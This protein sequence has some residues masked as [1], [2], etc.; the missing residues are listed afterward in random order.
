MTPIDL[1]R[2]STSFRLTL[3]AALLL[4]GSIL[5]FTLP[6]LAQTTDDTGPTFDNPVIDMNFPDP[7]MLK[8]ED[9]YYAYS[10]NS[11]SR[12]VPVA[13]STDL[14]NWKIGRDVMPAL[15]KWVN[16]SGPDVWAPEVLQVD[17]QFLLYY[18]ARDKASGRQCIGV[19]VSE[20]PGGPFRDSSDQALICQVREGGSIDASPFRDA[21]GSLYLYWKNDGNC[22]MMATWLYGQPL[23]DDGL[24]LV[25]EPVQL[26]R[27]DTLWEGTVVEAPSMWQHDDRYYLFYSGNM[28]STEK[29][30]VGYAVCET[31]LGPCEDAEENPILSSDMDE[32]P[33]V[34]GPGHQTLV[35]DEAGETW[36]YY[37]V[38][39]VTR[40]GSITSNR[41][42]WLDR[43]IWEDGVP[44]VVGPTREDQPVPVTAGVGPE[45]ETEAT[46]ETEASD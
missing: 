21:D 43:V 10:T 16:F 30:A 25:D 29:Y 5:I 26:V 39:E 1:H 15:A 17:D 46:A 22:C 23:S 44:S 40:S 3:L 8:V 9:T 13:T 6:V 45:T 4:I 38:W 11:S 36:I 2:F 27:N 24:T 32:Q 35:M 28:Y 41:E 33:L 19:A 12:N 42:V 7:F 34:V 14:V 31:P 20:A 18:T 37:H